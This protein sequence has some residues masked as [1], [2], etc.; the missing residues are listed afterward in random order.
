MSA[1]SKQTLQQTIEGLRLEG[2]GA[3][4][5]REW[6]PYVRGSSMGAVREDYS[7]EFVD[8]AQFSQTPLKNIQSFIEYMQFCG[9]RRQQA[10]DVPGFTAGHQQQAF[11]SCSL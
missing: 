11:V 1:E 3:A 4:Q 2:D 5:W 10:N 6:G 9:Q 8:S 7:A